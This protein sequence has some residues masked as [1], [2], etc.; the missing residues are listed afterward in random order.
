[1][2]FLKAF[3]IS[4][5]AVFLPI[6][7]VIFTVLVLILSDLVTGVLAAMKRKEKITSAGFRRTVVKIFVYETAIL[8]G[9]LVEKYILKDAMPVTKLISSVVG[10]VELKSLL[11]NLETI[12]GQSIF[13]KII[14]KLGSESE[15][16]K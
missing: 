11:E 15:Q 8:I 7:S 14:S 5:A 13:T 2:K 3:I 1:M 4:A 10:L 16:E 9:F 6:Q 12:Q